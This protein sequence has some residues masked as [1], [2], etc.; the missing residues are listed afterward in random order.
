M[1][2]EYRHVWIKVFSR[3]QTIQRISFLWQWFTTGVPQN[4]LLKM[5][6]L[7]VL[8]SDKKYDYYLY[9]DEWMDCLR[10]LSNYLLSQ[11]VDEQEKEFNQSSDAFLKVAKRVYQK[12][13]T[14]WSN[15]KL[16]AWFKQHL[17]TYSYFSLCVFPPWAVDIILAPKLKHELEKVNPEKAN[18]WFEAISS[19]TRP[20]RMTQQQIDL[21]KI[22]IS[23]NFAK[24]KKHVQK[25]CWLPIYNLG[26]QPW[27]AE[28]FKKQL[29][30]IKD[31][32]RELKEKINSFKKKQ[33]EYNTALQEIK[34]SPDLKRLIETV[35]L[36][37]FLRNERVDKWRIVLH[38]IEQFYHEI[39][40]RANILPEDAANFFNEEIMN[41]LEKEILP[42]DYA[43]R[44]TQNALLYRDGI[45]KIFTKTEDIEKLRIQELG[46]I[47]KE[48]IKEVKGLPAYKGIVTGYVR[49]IRTPQDL[50]SL[51]QGEILVAHHTSPDFVL[52]MKRSAAIVTDEGGITSHAAIVSRE[53]KIPCVTATKEGSNVFKTGDFIEVN[54][55]KL[56]EN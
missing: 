54:A 2:S 31:Q 3:A 29:A 10:K 56:L 21:L 36:Y 6:S 55:E 32:K 22:G 53:L 16:I 35:H 50:P 34:P 48:E 47:T 11:S 26:E 37:T 27:T 9:E 20:D 42:E 38:Q 7:L 17:D 45:R 39:A 12:D 1:S 49:V 18:A 8:P 4:K 13:L 14:K 25:Y 41:Y 33:S 44:K 43:Q 52:A 19:Q 51:K 46:E 24:L 23:G 40:R 5:H 30:E 15:K 28:D